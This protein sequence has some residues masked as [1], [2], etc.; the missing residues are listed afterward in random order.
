[1]RKT[2][3]RQ[4]EKERAPRERIFYLIRDPIV[5]FFLKKIECVCV[6]LSHILMIMIMMV[7]TRKHHDND[8]DYVHIVLFC[9]GMYVLSVFLSLMVLYRISVPIFR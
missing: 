2:I 7:L 5:F 3:T 1:M 8:H 6:F 4:Y 9:H